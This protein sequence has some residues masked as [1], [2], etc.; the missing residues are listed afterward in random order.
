MG[1]SQITRQDRQRYIEVSGTPIGRSTG[2]VQKDIRKI[3]DTQ[4]FLPTGYYWD[5]GI[6]QKRQA[7]EFGG[8]P[9]AVFLAIGLIYMLL[10]AQFESYIHPLTILFSVP[11][12][13]TGVILAL[14][15]SDRSF[16]LTAFIG[17]LTVS[18]T[19]LTLPTI[20]SV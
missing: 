6:N 14:I 4:T 19:H 2:D 20:Y 16:G 12:A 17:V 5:W 13:I 8:M 3:L 10:A 18:Y 1:P 15:I 7:E 11:L 9:I